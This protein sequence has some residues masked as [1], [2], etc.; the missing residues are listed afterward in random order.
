[1]RALLQF[2]FLDSKTIHRVLYKHDSEVP[3]TTE[4]ENMSA[5]I[6]DEPSYQHKGINLD[7]SVPHLY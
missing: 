4:L 2:H 1:M 5:M 3:I 6:F 7:K